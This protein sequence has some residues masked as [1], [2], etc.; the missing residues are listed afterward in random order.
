MSTVA[1]A[2]AD[3]SARG[4]GEPAPPTLESCLNLDDFEVRLSFGILNDLSSDDSNL[5]KAAEALLKLKAWGEA[6]STRGLAGRLT[7][8]RDSVL[9][10]SGRR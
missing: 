2:E 5:Q 4:A 7:L 1:K 6:S 10:F 3:V 9:C 8:R